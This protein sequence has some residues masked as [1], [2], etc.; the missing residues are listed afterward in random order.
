M[1]GVLER[2]VVQ[3]HH[4]CVR[5]PV[6]RDPAGQIDVHDV[7][8]AASEAQVDR[9]RIHHHVVARLDRSGQSGVGDR[10]PPLAFHLNRDLRG[11]TRALHRHH[12]AA[13]QNEPLGH[14]ALWATMASVTSSIV[15][16]ASML[17]LSSGWWF[18]SVPFATLRQLKPLAWNT[19]ASL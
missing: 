13:P 10:R 16:S 15:S 9:G 5:R 11:R 8:A 4:V 12:G 14:A 1:Y 6:T 18:A 17:T 3:L 7:E 2:R 19:F